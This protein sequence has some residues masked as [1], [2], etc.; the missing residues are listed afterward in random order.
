MPVLNADQ[1]SSPTEEPSGTANPASTPGRVFHQIQTGVVR[2]LAAEWDCSEEQAALRLNVWLEQ[3]PNP[4]DA[5]P[6]RPDRATVRHAREHYHHQRRAMD[7]QPVM[8]TTPKPE[9]NDDAVRRWWNSDYRP[10]DASNERPGSFLPVRDA[11]VRRDRPVGEQDA[12]GGGVE[13]SGIPTDA[14]RF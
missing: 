7:R 9:G 11:E 1:I 13:S 6:D 14:V 5:S 12:S 8:T 4:N 10:S 2:V 3:N